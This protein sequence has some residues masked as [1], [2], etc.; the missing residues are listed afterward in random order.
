MRGVW[1]WDGEGVSGCGDV[2]RAR[3]G[4]EWAG[5]VGVHTQLLGPSVGGGH[6]G[7]GWR[8][9][10]EAQDVEGGVAASSGH[11]LLAPL[12]VHGCA[13]LCSPDLNAH[14]AHL[15]EELP[16]APLPCHRLQAQA[17]PTR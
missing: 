16:P 8:M 11:T 10:A 1:C 2:G 6:E 5:W 17:L 14:L 12:P 3:G 4:A 7:V 9:K 13:A 15:C